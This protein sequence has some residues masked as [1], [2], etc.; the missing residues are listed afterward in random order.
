VV[1]EERRRLRGPGGEP[2]YLAG[3]EATPAGAQSFQSAGPRTGLGVRKQLDSRSQFAETARQP[4][5]E[6]ECVGS[7]R[8]DH[9][10]ELGTSSCSF[11]S[12]SC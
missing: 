6:L 11:S 12:R 2:S 3:S 1:A 10:G 5:L 7:R 8:L 4:R 9:R